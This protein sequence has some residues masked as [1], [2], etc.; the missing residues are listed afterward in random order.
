MKKQIKKEIF[1]SQKDTNFTWKDIKHI[2]FQDD[3]KIIITYIEPYHSENESYDG[4]YIAEVTR[5]VEESDEEFMLRLRRED[6]FNKE[7]KERRRQQYLKLKQE[8]ENE[9]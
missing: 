5:M 9:E 7:L 4:H 2:D 3:D 6:V 8:F 1:W